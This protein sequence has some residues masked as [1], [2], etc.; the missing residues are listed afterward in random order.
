MIKRNDIHDFIRGI[1]L[2][3]YFDNYNKTHKKDYEKI[4]LGISNKFEGLLPS[5]RVG[6]SIG[7]ALDLGYIDSAQLLK[8]HAGNL[9][10]D[11][12]KVVTTDNKNVNYDSQFYYSLLLMDKKN[13]DN[14]LL[15]FVGSG[16]QILD[17]I[18]PERK[19]A[20]KNDITGS[21][22]SGIDIKSCIEKITKEKISCYSK[23]FNVDPE[24]IT[25][26][27]NEQSA[28]NK[29]YLNSG[30][31]CKAIRDENWEEFKKELRKKTNK[32]FAYYLPDGSRGN[33]FALALQLNYYNAA[34]YIYDHAEEFKIEVNQIQTIKNGETS[35]KSAQEVLN[36]SLES[37]DKYEDL[38]SVKEV[39][40]QFG[41]M[42]AD[43]YQK[44]I[45]ENDNALNRLMNKVND[46]EQANNKGIAKKKTL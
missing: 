5:G 39:R 33:A 24:V 28:N 15:S 38:A 8:S 25:K 37:Y 19:T 9:G 6:N 4:I 36:K 17:A 12:E 31:L 43:E 23:H 21:I 40:L 22:F 14:K 27:L 44:N 7:L 11:L 46:K 34:E 32:R 18:F 2:A 29:A 1:V 16:D 30:K 3:T 26:M 20:N 41:D 45:E 35:V 10:I 42:I 13:T